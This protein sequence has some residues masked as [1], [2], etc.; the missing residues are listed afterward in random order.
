[1]LQHEQE[2]RFF[3]LI[4]VFFFCWRFCYRANEIDS[5]LVYAALTTYRL[6]NV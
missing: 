6:T 1:M 4:S 3:W 5:G 2:V